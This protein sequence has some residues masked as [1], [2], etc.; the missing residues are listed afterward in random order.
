MTHRWISCAAALALSLF[1]C[2]SAHATLLRFDY[3]GT[4]ATYGG[5]FPLDDVIRVGFTIDI[6]ALAPTRLVFRD[7]DSDIGQIVNDFDVPFLV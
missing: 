5:G 1:A 3:T 2:T 7:G 6:G 4:V